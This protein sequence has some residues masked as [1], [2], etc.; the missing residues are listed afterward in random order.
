MPMSFA[1]D[2][3]H[4][5]GFSLVE[6]LCALVIAATSIVVLTGGVTGT[7][8]STRA[9]D[10]QLG[11]RIILQSILEDELASGATAT[12]V[13]EGDSGPYRWRLDIAPAVEGAAARLPMSH[14]MYRL[15]ASVS[16]G[17]GGSTSATVLKLAR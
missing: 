11:A 1:A 9:L 4:Q 7:L 6:V 10:M 3:S 12:V 16:W 13:R 2:P 14:R 8:K 17:R 5:A 15:T